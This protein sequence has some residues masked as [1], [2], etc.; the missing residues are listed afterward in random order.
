MLRYQ[1]RLNFF[2]GTPSSCVKPE[3]TDTET[4]HKILILIIN[5]GPFQKEKNRFIWKT[6]LLH[7]FKN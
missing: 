7:E 6:L 5:G 3:Q 1:Q 4:E 2:N